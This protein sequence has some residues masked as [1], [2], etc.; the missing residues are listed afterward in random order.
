M[1]TAL[2]LYSLY[3]FVNLVLILIHTYYE[4]ISNFKKNL[5]VPLK[6]ENVSI[7]CNQLSKS[8]QSF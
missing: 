1:P 7:F 3:L 2:D 8:V 4:M 5:I 6:P